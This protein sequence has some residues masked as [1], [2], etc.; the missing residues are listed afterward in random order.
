[1]KFC[2]HK[3]LL[4]ISIFIIINNVIR[5]FV[6]IKYPP[7]MDHSFKRIWS[8][9]AASENKEVGNR[10]G[11]AVPQQTHRRGPRSEVL[12]SRGSSV[13]CHVCCCHSEDPASRIFTM[14]KLNS[15]PKNKSPTWWS[16][17][18]QQTKSHLRC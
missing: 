1:M 8:F 6:K 14:V 18:P 10:D 16:G 5:H 17:K 15:V 9:D 12:R 4:C 11:K 2:K 13:G 3:C 7:Y